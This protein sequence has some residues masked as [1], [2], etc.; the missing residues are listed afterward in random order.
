MR[1]ARQAITASTGGRERLANRLDLLWAKGRL[2]SSAAIL[3]LSSSLSMV[4]SPTLDFSRA[5]S[6][7]RSKHVD[8]IFNAFAAVHETRSLGLSDASH[9]IAALST[10]RAALRRASTS[11]MRKT[12]MSWFD[13]RDVETE[14]R[15]SQ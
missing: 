3:A 8:R 11:R 1:N 12:C 7:S 10:R 6:S 15:L 9:P 2:P 4:I 14:A 5:I 13:E